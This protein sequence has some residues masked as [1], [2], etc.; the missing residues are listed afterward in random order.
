MD[1]VRKAFVMLSAAL[2]MS[3]LGTAA[4][5]GAAPPARKGKDKG[6]VAVK[7]QEQ[8][9]GKKRIKRVKP[10]RRRPADFD[11]DLSMPAG[12]AYDVINGGDL[13]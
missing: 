12:T 2:T 9:R 1:N 10:A 7:K 5:A 11:P 3:A 13:P 4:A 6:K 8:A